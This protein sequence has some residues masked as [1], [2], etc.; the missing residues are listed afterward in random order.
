MRLT[1]ISNFG[2]AVIAALVAI[3]WGCIL[4]ERSIRRHAWEETV[5]MLRSNGVVPTR[6]PAPPPPSKRRS[7]KS[8]VQRDL[9]V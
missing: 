8:S 7:G 3:L 9:K 2:L 5:I 1:G 4:A 6:A